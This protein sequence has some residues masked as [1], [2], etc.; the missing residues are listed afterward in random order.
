MSE[1]VLGWGRMFQGV[2]SGGIM[3]VKEVYVAEVL[4]KE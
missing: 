4:T 2:W 3:I 1:G